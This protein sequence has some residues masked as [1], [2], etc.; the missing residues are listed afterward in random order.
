MV[1]AK[2]PQLKKQGANIRADYRVQSHLIDLTIVQTGAALK[3]LKAATDNAYKQKLEQYQGADLGSHS[4]CNIMPLVF[5]GSGS[6]HEQ[7]FQHLKTLRI[8]NGEKMEASSFSYWCKKMSFTVA[9][10]TT[11]S[12]INW[13][14]G[15]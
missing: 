13:W 12:A 9:L 5:T 11:S 3:T 8:Y 6:I 4:G 10:A 2:E 15:H 7:T 1:S 14:K